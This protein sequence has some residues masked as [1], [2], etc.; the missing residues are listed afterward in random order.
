MFDDG[1]ESAAECGF[2]LMSLLVKNI[3]VIYDFPTHSADIKLE[4][5]FQPVLRN[6]LKRLF[7]P[8]N[9]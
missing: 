5:L 4:Y 3:S 7:N 2:L 1:V 9:Y 8:Y 6:G